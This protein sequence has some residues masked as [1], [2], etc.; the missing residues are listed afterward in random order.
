[1]CFSL[2]MIR[3]VLYMYNWKKNFYNIFNENLIDLLMCIY[4]III[5]FIIYNNKRIK[6]YY[7]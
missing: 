2:G 5:K 7:F 1:M 6:Y 3:N 4:N